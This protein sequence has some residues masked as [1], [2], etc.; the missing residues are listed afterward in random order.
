MITDGQLKIS[1][2]LILKLKPMK[3][4]GQTIENALV[5]RFSWIGKT[6]VYIGL[7]D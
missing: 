3:F 5:S 2:N 7:I 6:S 4:H 1:M